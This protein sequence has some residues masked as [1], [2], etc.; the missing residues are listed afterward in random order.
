MVDVSPSGVPQRTGEMQ[1]RDGR[2]LAWSEWGPVDGRPVLL[3]HGAPGSGHCCPDV[4]A[5]MD[6]GVRLIA[7]D[8]PGYGTSDPRPGRTVRSWAEDTRQLLDHLAIPTVPIV[9][10]SSGVEYSMACAAGMPWR[11]QALALIAGDAPPDEVP[12]SLPPEVIARLREDP[13][14]SRAGLLERFAWFADEPESI[15]ERAPDPP[16][17]DPDAALRAA[18]PALLEML[19]AMF[20]H[21]ARQGAAGWVDDTLAH[22][23]P[24]GFKPSWIGART[25][26]WFGEGDRLAE[27]E[28]S[29]HLART[30]KHATLRLV[31]DAGHSLP[32]AHWADVL[33]DLLA[34]V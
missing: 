34:D 22:A 6:H 24:W 12:G 7:P 9:G 11:V 4:A 29:E 32:I 3:F 13:A 33:D 28:H 17:G 14:G 10:W 31:P 18:N 25:T 2:A 21:A 15:L 8:R 20:R 23:L 27:R 30:L 19:R 16:T 5:T 26:V 1:L